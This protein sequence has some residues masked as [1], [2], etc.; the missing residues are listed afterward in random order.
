[1]LIQEEYVN[2]TEGRRMGSDEPYVPFTE[3]IG[4]LFRRCQKEYGRCTGHVYIDK[5]DGQTQAIGWVF[6]RTEKY[7][8]TQ[9]PYLR[10]VW[11]TLH[12]APV[13]ITHQPHYHV[14]KGA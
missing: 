7:E 6:E 12:D 2:A 4:E 3:N 8:N 5:K 14:L 13:T 1:M 10:Q 11:V 9:K